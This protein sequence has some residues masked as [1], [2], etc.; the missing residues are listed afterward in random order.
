MGYVIVKLLAC[1]FLNA[2]SIVQ[3]I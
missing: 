3:F 2:Q 1:I